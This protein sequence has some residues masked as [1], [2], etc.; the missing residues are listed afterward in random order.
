[1]PT[2][3]IPLSWNML[4]KARM[5]GV[6][7]QPK[8]SETSHENTPYGKLPNRKGNIAK[9]LRSLINERSRSAISLSAV[10]SSGIFGIFVY[11]LMLNFG[12]ISIPLRLENILILKYKILLFCTI[13]L[14]HNI[15]TYK[16]IFLTHLGWLERILK[17]Y[18][19][20]HFMRSL[21]G[22]HRKH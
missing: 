15:L 17:K 18:I 19:F 21:G 4:I 5:S 3:V 16:N 12:R 6:E 7:L 13:I 11:E 9:Q 2:H 14:M 8:W 20:S 1:M 22:I 10:P